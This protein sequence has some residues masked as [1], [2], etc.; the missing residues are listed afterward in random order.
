MDVLKGKVLQLEA[1]LAVAKSSGPINVSGEDLCALE[2]EMEREFNHKLIGE[3]EVGHRPAAW[4]WLYVADMRTL[5]FRGR[6]QSA[7]MRGRD[8]ARESD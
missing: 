2:L 3:V 7:T 5:G 6:L 1:E 4:A 8:T